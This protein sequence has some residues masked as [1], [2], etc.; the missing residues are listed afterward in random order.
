MQPILDKTVNVISTTYEGELSPIN[1]LHPFY[2]PDNLRVGYWVRDF[3]YKKI[4]L[5]MLKNRLMNI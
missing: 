3:V 4:F 2:S 5:M 1:C